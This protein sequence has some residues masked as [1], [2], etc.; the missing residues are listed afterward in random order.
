MPLAFQ[1]RFATA[2]SQT[3]ALVVYAALLYV[4]FIFQAALA[5]AEALL[6]VA[7]APLAAAQAALLR[8]YSVAL[9]QRVPLVAFAL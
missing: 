1:C 7:K 5:V 9:A 2:N 8:V 3:E 6:L 4:P